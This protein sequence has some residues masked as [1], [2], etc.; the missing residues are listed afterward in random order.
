MGAQKVY[1]QR[2][3][4]LNLI[5]LF[6]R[7]FIS[8]TLKNIATNDFSLTKSRICLKANLLIFFTPQKCCQNV[9]NRYKIHPSHWCYRCSIK[10]FYIWSLELCW[11]PV[12]GRI[13]EWE[14]LRYM[15]SIVTKNYEQGHIIWATGPTSGAHLSC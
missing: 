10:E 3:N 7:N 13:Y 14:T 2:M 12:V 8:N 4:W 15:W 1:F 9:I 11:F 6:T 5:Q